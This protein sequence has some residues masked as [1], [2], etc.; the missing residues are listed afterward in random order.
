MK[1]YRIII[2]HLCRVS[3]GGRINVDSR[4][5]QKKKEKNCVI[6]LLENNSVNHV[7]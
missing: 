7:V 6:F 2:Y 1:F 3:V 4:Q 5:K